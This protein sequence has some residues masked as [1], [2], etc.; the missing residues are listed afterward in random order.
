MLRNYLLIGLR[1]LQKH[2]FYSIINISGLAIGLAASLLLVTW[3]I[4]ESSY[5]KFHPR[6]RQIH[7]ASLEYSFG[8]QTAKTSVSP[9]ALLPALQKNFQEVE[10]GVRLYN[11]S[12]W[13]PYV[14]RQG[15]KLFQEEKFLYADSTFFEVFGYTPIK[16]NPERALTQP[17][18]VILTVSTAS[19]YFGN[20]DALGK[21]LQINNGIDYVVTA[22]I[23]DAPTNSIL[24]FDFIASFASLNAAKAQIWWSA[25]YDT[26]VRL[27]RD[28]NIDLLT[29]K[30]QALVQQELAGEL[31]NPGDYVKYNYIPLPDIYLRSDMNESIPVGDI[32]YVYI[33]GAIAA[34]IL[35][36]ACINY[37]N[38][39]TARAADRAKEVGVRKVAGAQR[40]QLMLQFLG[41]SVI[42]TMSSLGFALLLTRLVIPAF[43]S[44]TGKSF[45]HDIIFNP[46][47]LVGMCI[48]AVGIALLAGA[49]PAIAITSFRPVSV[50]KGNFRSSG[51]GVWL[52]KSLVVF[53]FTVSIALI[54]GTLV[55]KRQ[56]DYIQRKKLGYEKEN[57]IILP[58]DRKTEDIYSQLRTELLRDESV[59]QVARATESPTSIAGG[60]SINLEGSAN[61]LGMIVTAMSVDPEF[62]PALEMKIIEG[63]NFTEG[64]MLK[65]RADTVYAFVLNESAI[66]ELGIDVSQAVGTDVNMNGRKGQIIGVLEDFHFATMQKKITPLVLFNQESDYNHIFV[67]LK[68]G[69]NAAAIANVKSVCEKLAPHRPFEYTFLD[70]QYNAMYHNEQRMAKIVTTF[71][72]LTIFVACL[73]LF[74]LVAFSVAQKT[75]EIGIRKVLGASASSIVLLMAR[76]FTR[77]VVL[78]VI[79]GI[80]VA[81]YV[82][83]Q[84]MAG[85]A[86]QAE[87]GVTPFVLA[88]A[89]CLLIAM[90]TIS[91]QAIKAALINPTETLRSE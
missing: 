89:V 17:N 69:D 68:T 78:S 27:A 86:Y 43:D 79:V 77:L 84:W 80:P 32:Q 70:Q 66:R 19:K 85:F 14:V 81:Y 63:R 87:I 15:A 61:D 71:A 52:R 2:R 13:S 28:T 56:L 37:V 16:G 62:V 75:K 30:T 6:A 29:Q 46:G 3:I 48:I 25:N 76:D 20:E 64:D 24:Q 8:G 91:F 72:V 5:D 65:A 88:C 22:I 67:K 21:V 82:V 45:A 57:T 59:A 53:Q 49:Y 39:A 73:G 41:E 31:A 47:F 44:I 90:V 60:Y 12:A 18:S 55:V 11:P 4:H 36:I 38:L 9:T 42:V 50:L 33:F 35:I 51:K 7:R 23:P 74:G 10:T 26:Y 1:S 34:L 54:I 40:Q 58:L 83:S